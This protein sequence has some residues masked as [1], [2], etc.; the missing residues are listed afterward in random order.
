MA[1]IKKL[2]DN[3][4]IGGTDNTDVYPVTSTEAVYNKENVSQEYINNHVDGSKIVDNTVTS[5]KLADNSVSTRTIQGGVVTE[6]K[7]ADAAVSTR[8][9]QN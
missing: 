2:K 8:T 4:L 7:L 9:I 5:L 6:P 1:Y 3:E